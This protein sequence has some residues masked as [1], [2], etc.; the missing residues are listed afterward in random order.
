MPPTLPPAG[1]KAELQAFL[2]DTGCSFAAFALQQHGVES[3]G[4]LL[5][6]P[7]HRLEALRLVRRTRNIRHRFRP[8]LHFARFA[9]PQQ[10]GGAEQCGWARTCGPRR[11]RRRAVSKPERRWLRA[12]DRLLVLLTRRA[13]GGRGRHLII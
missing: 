11:R 6:F 12:P 13:A 2:R 1:S 5:S 9:G 8:S 7:Q 10:R 4:A 3:L